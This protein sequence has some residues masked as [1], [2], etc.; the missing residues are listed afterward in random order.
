MPTCWRRSC[1]S[2]RRRT[3][4]SGAFTGCCASRICVSYL[5]HYRRML[6]AVLGV[7]EFRSNNPVHRL[8]LDAV[9]WLRRTSGSRR[10]LRPEDGVPLDGVVPPKWRDLVVEKDDDGRPRINRINYEI[11]VLIALRERLR[12]KEI[13]VVGAD[14]YRNPDDDLPRDFE[15][16]R[17][18]CYLL[19]QGR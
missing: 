7:L 16:R 8:V 15:T 5:R 13:L 1:E 18:D 12:C 11:C 6:P 4:S 3:V 2:I 17:A 14:R 19:R 10:V 9:D